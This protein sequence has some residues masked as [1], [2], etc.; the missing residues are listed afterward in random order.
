[1]HIGRRYRYHRFLVWTR[2]EAGYLIFV[3]AVRHRVPSSLELEFSNDTGADTD[4]CRI[5]ACNCPRVQE[6]AMLRA[7]Q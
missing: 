1:M 5:G 6:S 7:L 4:N 3:V 2:W